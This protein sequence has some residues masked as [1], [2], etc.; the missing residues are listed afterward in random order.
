MIRPKKEKED[1]LLSIT[2]ICE[3][4]IDQTHRKAQETLESKKTKPRETFHSKS[5]IQVKGDWILGLT[6]LEVYSFI[7]DKKEANN[8][9]KFYKLPDEKSGGV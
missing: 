4:L 9:F 8:K 1:L 7:F 3:T 5:P 6:A 2:K